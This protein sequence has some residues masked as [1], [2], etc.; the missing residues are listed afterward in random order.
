MRWRVSD[1]PDDF[2]RLKAIGI[3]VAE[4]EAVVKIRQDFV[5]VLEHYEDIE[6]AARR[7]LRGRALAR[8]R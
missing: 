5:A 7:V 1:A 8:F 6:I 3:G 2:E 4:A